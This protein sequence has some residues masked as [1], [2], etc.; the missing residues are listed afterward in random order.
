VRENAGNFFVWHTTEKRSS[1]R[2]FSAF[3]TDFFLFQHNEDAHPDN[4]TDA[5][6][7]VSGKFLDTRTH[8]RV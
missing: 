2:F 7:T 4:E 6:L 3:I 5:T 1:E 8:W